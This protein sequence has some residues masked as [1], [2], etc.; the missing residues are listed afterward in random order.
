[1]PQLIERTEAARPAEKAAPGRRTRAQMQAQAR[2]AVL[3]AVALFILAQVGM[4]GGIE[5]A[6]PELRDPAFEIK[7]RQYTRLKNQVGPA[8]A[9]V[10]FMGSSLTAHGMK[11]DVV[12][13]RASAAL[14][15]PV[16]GFNLGT[17]GSGPLTQLVYLHRLLQ[18]GAKPELVI[19]ELSPIFF[20]FADRLNDIDRFPAQVLSR[21]D[22]DT[23]TRFVRQPDDLRDEWRRCCIV[24]IHGH[25]LT[26][27]N[28]TAPIMVPFADRVELSDDMDAHGWRRRERPEPA[29]HAEILELVKQWFGPRLERFKVGGPPVQ[30]LRELADLLASEQI[31]TVM[32]VMPEGPLMRSLYAPGSL[33]PLMNEFAEISRKYGFPLIPARCWFGEEQF[34]DSYHLTDQAAEEF[35]ERLVREAILPRLRAE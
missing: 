24:P 5:G 29:R 3:G 35:T 15:R 4:R 13:Q 6:R 32:V 34:T 12:D 11:A 28:Q 22:L 30:V 1:M 7:Y 33:D 31:P 8:P 23:V 26:I 17:N 16:I 9:T 27:L 25:R 18:R 20:D 19:L 10:L 21:S 14:G 2:F